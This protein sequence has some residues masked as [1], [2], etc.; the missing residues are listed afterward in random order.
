[1]AFWVR[2]KK[3]KVKEV[4]EPREVKPADEVKWTG[5]SRGAENYGGGVASI[6]PVTGQKYDSLGRPVRG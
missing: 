4:L 1:M 3:D 2:R 6:N 5:T